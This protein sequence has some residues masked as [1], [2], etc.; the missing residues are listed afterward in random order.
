M[1]TAAEVT[2]AAGE[3]SLRARVSEGV[4]DGPLVVALHGASYDARYFD[5]PGSSVHDRLGDDGFSV[6]AITRYGYPADAR[7]AASQPDFAA[8]AALLEQAIAD[9]W[10]R[11]GAGR[12]GVVVLGH[13]VGAAI[14][15]HLAASPTTWPLLGLAISG[16]GDRPTAG[17]A[18]MFGSLPR[19]VVVDLPF[20]QVRRAFYGPDH[21]L[22]PDVLARA[23][24]LLVP[25]PSSDP[26][27]VNTDWPNDLPRLAANVGVP[28]MYTLV[29]GDGLWQWGDERVHAFASLF[30][31]APSVSAQSWPGAGHNLEHHRNGVEFLAQVAEFARRCVR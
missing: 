5:V 22:D 27:E 3:V 29:E 12:P 30:T 2:L 31:D 15:V 28:V 23:S 18:K 6:V 25:F 9:A 24:G 10:G 14:G 19:T 16:I 7:T 21:A 1:A 4:G 20:E 8:S 17:P 11:W 26:V 13:S